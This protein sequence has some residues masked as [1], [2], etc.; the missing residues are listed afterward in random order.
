MPAKPARKIAKVQ[1]LSPRK[2]GAQ[3]ARR[4]PAAASA[5]AT[6]S[7]AAPATPILGAGWGDLF[8]PALRQNAD[9]GGYARHLA[10]RVKVTDATKATWSSVGR[11]SSGLAGLPDTAR[12]NLP[13]VV[14]DASASK[15]Y[16]AVASV[17]S[18]GG[19]AI[20]GI[21]ASADG[22]LQ[23]PFAIGVDDEVH[24][25]FVYAL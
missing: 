8:T 19:I 16:P 12:T 5:T 20:T 18:G 13:C 9:L 7:A 6:L 22:S 3:A 14:R 1:K 24:L 11:V 23:P 10:M 21:A 17:A 2:S 15:S 4:A 25:S